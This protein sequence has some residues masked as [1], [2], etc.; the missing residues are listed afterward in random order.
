MVVNTLK[1]LLSLRVHPKHLFTPNFDNAFQTFQFMHQFETLPICTIIILPPF[2]NPI[3]KSQ[4][5]FC[6]IYEPKMVGG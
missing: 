2:S 3:L 4:L 1:S 6:Y 5:F